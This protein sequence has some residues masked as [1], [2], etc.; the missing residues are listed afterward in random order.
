MHS[1]LTNVVTADRVWEKRV[2][3][4]LGTEPC[5]LTPYELDPGHY[6]GPLFDTHL[7][8][9]SIPDA[10]PI[11]EELSSP[12]LDVANLENFNYAFPQLGVNITI[13]EIACTLE[14]ERTGGA[15]SFFPVF[16]QTLDPSLAVVNRSMEMYPD[17]FFPFINALGRDEGVP[18]VGNGRSNRNTCDL[19]ET[20]RRVR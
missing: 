18:T 14:Y 20:L 19:S 10:R 2:E 9:P 7:H 4:G 1:R 12:F 6:T 13:A 15:I 17:L 16:Q 3:R 11:E 5:D 8:I